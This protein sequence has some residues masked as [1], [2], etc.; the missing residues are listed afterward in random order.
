MIR[1]EGFCSDAVR[2]KREEE[3]EDRGE[4]KRNKIQDKRREW[5]RVEV[6]SEIRPRKEERR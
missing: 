3:I 6:R 4:E 5:L 1:V 2:R